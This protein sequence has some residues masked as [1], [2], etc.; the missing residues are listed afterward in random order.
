MYYPLKHNTVQH[1]N[2]VHLVVILASHRN[3]VSFTYGSSGLKRKWSLISSF[4]LASSIFASGR[5]SPSSSPVNV[6]NASTDFDCMLSRSCKVSDWNLQLILN[7]IMAILHYRMTNMFI[8]LMH[9][10][11]YMSA[12]RDWNK[13]F[14]RDAHSLPYLF[15]TFS[16]PSLPLSFSVIF[17]I[18]FIRL[19]IH[20]YILRRH[21]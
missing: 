20:Q 9:V 1:R 21:L 11:S 13:Q 5:Y 16:L 3:G 8:V 6:V 19:N 10:Y 14:I 15:I 12:S 7:T 18:H 4:C 2:G 17:Q